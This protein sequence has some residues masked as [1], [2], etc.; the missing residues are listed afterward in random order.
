ME[1]VEVADTYGYLLGVWNVERPIED[2][3]CGMSGAFAGS[4]SVCQL[5]GELS[6]AA[7]AGAPPARRQADYREC[8]TLRWSGRELACAR[9]MLL[10][11]TGQ[12]RAALRFADGR[13]FVDVDFGT[14]GCEVR[15]DCGDDVYLIK[16][17]VQSADCY[18]ERWEV[19]GPDKDYRAD[20]TYR[21]DRGEVVR[22][23]GFCFGVGDAHQ[24][25]SLKSR[26]TESAIASCVPPE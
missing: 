9:R 15:H 10:A 14:G 19:K 24:G 16:F 1:G 7:H 12:G 26:R 8:G 5:V 21:R 4:V 3:H 13:H 25:P 17:L 2:Y 6:L 20:G 18:E 22:E 23:S 11:D